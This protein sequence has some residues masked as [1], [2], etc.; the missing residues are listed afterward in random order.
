MDMFQQIFIWLNAG[1][2]RKNIR[3][4]I[5][6]DDLVTAKYHINDRGIFLSFL[7]HTGFA[8]VRLDSG[9]HFD[10]MLAEVGEN[11]KYYVLSL[12]GQREWVRFDVEAGKYQSVLLSKDLEAPGIFLQNTAG[13]GLPW[14]VLV[15]TTFLLQD[16]SPIK[17]QLRMEGARLKA[18]DSTRESSEVSLISVGGVESSLPVRE[19]RAGVLARRLTE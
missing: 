6:P 5:H 1:L 4:Q 12:A 16:K 9:S 3:L 10:W 17:V 2:L 13:K 8:R 7:S 14:V 19:L 11:E 15:T 18:Y